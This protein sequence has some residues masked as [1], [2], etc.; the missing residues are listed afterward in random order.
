M[1]YSI[2][3]CGKLFSVREAAATLGL[4]EKSLRAWVSSG[5]IGFVKVGRLTKIPES[6]ILEIVARGYRRARS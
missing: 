2:S 5:K 3:I 1:D 6:Q 4:G